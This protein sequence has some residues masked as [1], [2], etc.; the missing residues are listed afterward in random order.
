MTKARDGFHRTVRLALL[1]VESWLALAAFDL[2]RPA[3]F[4]RMASWLKRRHARPRRTSAAIED[5]VWSVDEACVW[6][7]K[8]A[9]CLQRS[10]VGTWL[11]RKHGIPAQMVIG[12]RPLPFE[13]HAWIEVDGRV[14]NDRA[15]YP[16]VFTVLAR[17]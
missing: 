12:C 6:Y 10:L 3:G 16:R 8:R 2:A 9:L 4:A 13:S 17:F 7:L 1:T 11:L 5:I 15:Q 14:V